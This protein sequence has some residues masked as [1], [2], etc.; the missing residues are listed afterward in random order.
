MVIRGFTKFGTYQGIVKAVGFGA[1]EDLKKNNIR[2]LGP[3][4]KL[5]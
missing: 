4:L 3:K 1:F 5:S 2:R